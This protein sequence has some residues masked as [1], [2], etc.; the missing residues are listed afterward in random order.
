MIYVNDNLWRSARPKDLNEVK[1]AGF[2]IIISLESGLYEQISDTKRE[3]QFPADFGLTFYDFN[4][5]VA[6]APDE[7]RVAKFL[8]IVAKGKKTLVHCLH[9]EDRTGYMCA[10]YRMQVQDWSFKKAVAEW[11]L[12]GRKPMYFYWEKSLK[13]WEKK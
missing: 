8:E 7:R 3:Y 10:V 5:F 11:K 9:G 6:V 4:C 1:N 2:E 13:Q 12:L